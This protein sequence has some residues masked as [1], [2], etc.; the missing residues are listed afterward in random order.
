VALLLAALWGP[1][2]YAFVATTVNVYE[3]KFVNPLTVTGEDAPVPV[4]PPGLDVTV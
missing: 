2:P 4:N 3:V 1:V